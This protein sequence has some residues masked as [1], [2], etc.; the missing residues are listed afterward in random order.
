MILAGIIVIAWVGILVTAGVFTAQTSQADS[1][2][3][4]PAKFLGLTVSLV[5]IVGAIMWVIF[6]GRPSGYGEKCGAMAVIG[7]CWYVILQQLR[8][9]L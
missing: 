2:L 8:K 1:I 4:K 3:W 5:P 6:K 7:V 9:G